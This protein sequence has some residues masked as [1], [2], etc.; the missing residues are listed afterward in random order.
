VLSDAEKRKAYDRGGSRSGRQPVRGQRPGDGR[1]RGRLLLGHPLRPV[2]AGAAGGARARAGA[3]G[4]KPAQEK[5]RDLETEVSLAFDQA[6]EGAQVPVSVATHAPCPTCRGTGA[7]RAPEPIVCPVCQGRGVE[8]E[9]QGLFSI[10]RPCRRCEGSGTVVESPCPTCGGEGPQAGAQALQGQHPGGSQGR[11]ADPPRGQ[12]RGRPARWAVGRLVRHHAGPVLSV[13]EAKGDNL[14]VE[15]PITFA[16]AS[17]GADVEVP[18]L[19]APRRCASG[20]TKHGT[21]QRLRGEGRPSSARRGAG[22][23]TTAS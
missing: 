6:V 13:F 4:T 15:V 22:T 9:G 11:V 2:R 18:T 16:E 20:G 19:T 21:V 1:L 17:R 7:A 14:E 5:G 10:S 3:R 8:S 12:G 23:S